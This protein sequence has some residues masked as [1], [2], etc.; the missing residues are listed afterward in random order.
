ME[1]LHQTWF[2]NTSRLKKY[3]PTILSLEQILMKINYM[4]LLKEPEQVKTRLHMQ[5]YCFFHVISDNIFIHTWDVTGKKKK[6]KE[7]RPKPNQDSSI[8]K[9]KPSRFGF[10]RFKG[11]ENRPLLFGCWFCSKSVQTEPCTPLS[12]MEESRLTRDD[13][14]EEGWRQALKEVK[15]MNLRLSRTS[16]D[17]IHL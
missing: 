14:V 13:L 11:F 17:Q 3:T 4:N 15:V 8:Q 6:K 12:P 7:I 1:D 10:G 9:L 16:I 2:N 5:R